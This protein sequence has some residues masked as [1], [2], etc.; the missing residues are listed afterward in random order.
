MEE[1]EDEDD[2]DLDNDPNWIRIKKEMLM[3]WNFKSQDDWLLGEDVRLILDDH[4]R[5]NIGAEGYELLCQELIDLSQAEPKPGFV[6][7]DDFA[8]VAGA[9]IYNQYYD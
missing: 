2:I 9:F 1:E 6:N 3:M 4:L 8:E 7:R 5:A